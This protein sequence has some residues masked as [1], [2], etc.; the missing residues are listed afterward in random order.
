M[1]DLILVAGNIPVGDKNRE[2]SS[3]TILMEFI[4]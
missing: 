2:M 3:V 1:L 4:F